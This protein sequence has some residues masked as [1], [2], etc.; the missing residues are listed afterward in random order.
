MCAFGPPPAVSPHRLLDELGTGT[1]IDGADSGLVKSESVLQEITEMM[2][3]H[4]LFYRQELT[5]HVLE[6]SSNSNKSDTN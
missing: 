6:F 3:E 5:D 1:G 2:D 4:G